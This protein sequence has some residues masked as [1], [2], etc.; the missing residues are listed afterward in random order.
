MIITKQSLIQYFIHCYPE[1]SN[2][3]NND[4]NNDD[5]KTK[6]YE[7]RTDYILNKYGNTFSDVKQ[8]LIKILTKYNKNNNI[9]DED[10]KNNDISNEDTKNDDIKIK[11]TDTYSP[12]SSKLN[13]I[14]NDTNNNG[15][16]N[17]KKGKNIKQ[18]GITLYSTKKVIN[19]TINLN[20]NDD[21]VVL[22][23][24]KYFLLTRKYC[25]DKPMMVRLELSQLGFTQLKVIQ[26]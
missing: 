14:N 13:E 10:I 17:N 4:N 8:Y 11:L 9:N 25:L 1:L 23:K 22:L 2:N 5:T 15:N 24:T 20:I 26:Y 16:K 12:Y 3:N 21:D 7:E 19:N 6:F 18:H